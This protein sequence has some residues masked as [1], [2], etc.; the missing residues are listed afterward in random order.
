MRPLVV[1]GLLSSLLTISAA[2]GAGPLSVNGAQRFQVIDGFGVSV[3]SAS[4]N[5]A[6][7][8]PAIDDLTSIGSSIFRV[9]IDNTDW[10]T[11]N[12]NADPAVFNWTAY[13]QIVECARASLRGCSRPQTR[14][15]GTAS[16]GR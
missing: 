5:G 13:N 9:I 6:E 7:L 16:R 2:L 4:W 8:P 11:T 1:A 15:I 14:P 3:N 10:E 12:D